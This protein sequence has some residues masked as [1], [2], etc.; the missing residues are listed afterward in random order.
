MSGMYQI[1]CDGNLLHDIH[2]D[3]LKI[4]NPKASLKQNATSSFQFRIYPSHPYFNTIKKLKSII[5]IYQGND[6]IFRGRPIELKRA[7]NNSVD[8]YC[9]DELAYLIDSIQPPYDWNG[10]VV[11]LFTQF[12]NNH[13]SQVNDDHKFKL[14]IVTVTD[15][16]DYIVRADSDYTDTYSCIQDKFIDMLGGYLRVR[17]E[18]DGNYLDYLADFDTL[19]SQHVVFGE[20]M[21]DVK[22]TEDGA[23]I[24]TIIIPLGAK[25]EET[26]E[27]LTVADVNDGKIYIENTENIAKYGR[28]TKVQIW[29]DVTIPTNLYNKAVQSLAAMG[30]TIQSI[31]ISALDMASINEDITNF[32]MYSKIKVTS[33][34]HG[35]DDYFIP[36]KMDINLFEQGKNKITLN[37]EAK[38]LTDSSVATD[39]TT[40]TIQTVINNISNDYQVN[41]PQ[42]IQTLEQ[43]FASLIEQSSSLIYQEVSE[44][45]YNKDQSNELIE[46]VSTSLTQTKDF[47]EMQFNTFTQDLNDLLSNTNASFEDIRKYI[48]FEDGNIILGQIGNEFTLKITSERISFLQGSMELAY[49]NNSKLYIKALEILDNIQLGTFKWL[50]RANG[51]VTFKKV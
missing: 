26:G 11:G 8:V 29:D 25:D 9:E 37:G 19:N 48:R 27:R 36:L 31:E 2:M 41:I 40:N 16:N 28:I 20:N 23:D 5:L 46:S 49:M 38:T 47:F 35:I 4:Y 3:D 34:F 14:G 42:Q 24:A 44:K 39:S 30:Q 43:E 21:L 50:P 1:F 32:K 10:S 7:I 6:I 18:Q 22:R 33:A 15:P 45:Y 13:N 12:L 51:N 17:H